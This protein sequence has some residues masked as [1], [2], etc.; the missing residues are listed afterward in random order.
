MTSE[1]TPEGQGLLETP[2]QRLIGDIRRQTGLSYVEL[3][4][5]GGQRPDGR[6][7]IGKSTLRK[8]H[9]QPLFRPPAAT[10][11]ETLA[12]ICRVPVREVQ[13]AVGQ[14]LGLHPRRSGPDDGY[15]YARVLAERIEALPDEE[16]HLVFQAVE[17]LV[18]AAE[19]RVGVEPPP[20]VGDDLDAMFGHLLD[21]DPERKAR[22]RDELDAVLADSGRDPDGAGEPSRNGTGA[23]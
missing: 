17:L 10:T 7:W 23:G 22:W 12:R 13:D 6:A 16:R 19:T 21:A 2:F 4:R 11:M 18:E 3:A 5:L 14:S 8:F 9:C 15:S 1:T 20:A